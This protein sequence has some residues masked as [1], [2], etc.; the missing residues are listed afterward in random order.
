MSLIWGVGIICLVTDGQLLPYKQ[1]L[2]LIQLLKKR[3]FLHFNLLKV[4]GLNQQL[5]R[6]F[7]EALQTL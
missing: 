6:R 2:T 7:S 4:V 5:S 1:C 3:N